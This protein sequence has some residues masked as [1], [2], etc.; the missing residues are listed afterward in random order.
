MFYASMYSNKIIILCKFQCLR[1]YYFPIYSKIIKVTHIF[2]QFSVI[3]RIISLQIGKILGNRQMTCFKF[4]T[5]TYFTFSTLKR[6]Y[7]YMKK[8]NTAIVK[9]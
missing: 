1:H 5:S 8:K 6:V 2:R 4:S 3:F 9:V 7:I